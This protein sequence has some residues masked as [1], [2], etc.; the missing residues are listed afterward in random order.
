MSA[1][2]S[3]CCH[4]DCCKPAVWDVYPNNAVRPD[5]MGTQTCDVHLAEVGLTVV[6]GAQD[7]DY[8]R[9]YSI[10]PSTDV[11]AISC[12]L[13]GGW[14]EVHADP[15]TL[16]AIEGVG[17]ARHN[18]D[19]IETIAPDMTGWSAA[20]KGRC[21]DASKPVAARGCGEHVP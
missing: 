4:V 12:P 11:L 19:T 3:M 2:L 7:A 6:A 1:H 14:V 5:E 15:N 9:V 18:G 17:I 16:S 20:V 13:C 10:A 21:L 8:W